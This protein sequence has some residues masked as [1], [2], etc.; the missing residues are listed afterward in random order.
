MARPVWSG[1]LTF[2]LVTLPV[3]LYTATEDHTVHFHQLERDT[4]DRVRNRRVNERTGK[5]VAYQDL[6]KGYEIRPGEYVVVEPQELED[7]AP[8]RSRT[9]DIAGFVDLAD[10]E[11]IFFDRTYYLG[12]K[13]EEYAKIY[14]LL[15]EALDRTNR[16]GLALFSMRGK[17]YLTAV[18]AQEGLL[19]LHTMR[20]ADEIRDP[21]AEIDGL[22]TGATRVS[23]QELDTAQQLIE[24]MAID[25]KPE[26]WHDTYAEQVRQLVKDKA[27]GREIAVAEGPEEP[28]N[29]VDLMDALRRS[30]ETTRR[31]RSEARSSGSARP[32]PGRSRLSDLTKAQLYA[33]AAEL[34]VPGRSAMTRDE[35]EDAVRK[36]A[37]GGGR[38]QAA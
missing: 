1:V 24:M 32:T 26:E 36:A 37:R 9:I 12:P 17:E 23:K 34:E 35:L 15:V 21:R 29:V 27:A 6:V 2:G 10:V 19:E 20:F 30:L 3:A 18:R 7:I 8:G 11:P 4:G 22:P 38:N 28:T 31:E 5:E 16:A 13:G 25:W 14:K 33:R